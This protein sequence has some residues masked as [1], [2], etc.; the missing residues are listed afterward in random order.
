[1]SEPRL[2]LCPEDIDRVVETLRR[3]GGEHVS[4][5]R[6]GDGFGYRDGVFY[7]ISVDDFD[8]FDSPFADEAAFRAALAAMDFED[9]TD[10]YRQA[11]VRGLG[12]TPA[13]DAGDPEAV[14][15]GIAREGRVAIV[16]PLP[17]RGVACAMRT[18]EATTYL[19][20][21]PDEHA[22]PVWLALSS[23]ACDALQAE[24]LAPEALVGRTLTGTGPLVVDE[25]RSGDVAVRIVTRSQLAV[26][27]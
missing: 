13:M 16:T 15:R 11:V 17:W 23:D 20:I 5:G 22:R 12:A 25:P 27:R 14:R 18:G 2:R 6:T 7:A 21:S 26:G 3:R 1:M 24:E 19:R 8:R 4:R 9:N 10:R